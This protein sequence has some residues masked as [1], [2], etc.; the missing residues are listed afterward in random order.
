MTPHCE[1]GDGGRGC[2]KASPSCTLQA[3]LSCALEA[4]AS[5]AS[6]ASA[7]CALKAAVGEAIFPLLDSF[8]AEQLGAAHREVDAMRVAYS[9]LYAEHGELAR[10]LSRCTCPA[11]TSVE[12]GDKGAT[13]SHGGPFEDATTTDGE[14]GGDLLAVLADEATSGASSTPPLSA[15]RQQALAGDKR[16][17]PS[18]GGVLFN[19]V[20]RRR[21]ER[22]M[23]HGDDCPCCAKVGREG[24]PLARDQ[25]TLRA[26]NRHCARASSR[27][28]P[29]GGL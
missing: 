8:I 4:S 24:S 29:K 11:A 18:P 13:S 25:W 27:R 16:S 14:E 21:D 19:D 6:R 22:R 10:R 20:V 26:I 5:C 23:L 12:G 3:P 9:T 2:G 7:S 28:T 17:S 1:E 15:V